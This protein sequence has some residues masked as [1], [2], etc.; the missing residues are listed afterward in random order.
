MSRHTPRSSSCSRPAGPLPHP[1]DPAE[2]AADEG[3]PGGLPPGV[4][5]QHLREGR[6]QRDVPLVAGLDV[7]PEPR[8]IPHRQGPGRRV[9]SAG[10]RSWHSSPGRTPVSR[11]VKN[12]WNCPSPQAAK[13][14]RSWSGSNGSTGRACSSGLL[15]VLQP[16]PPLGQGARL[17]GGR[18]AA[19][20]PVVDLG[21]EP[22]GRGAVGPGPRAVAAAGLV[23]AEVTDEAPEVSS[24]L[25]D[26]VRGGRAWRDTLSEPSRHKREGLRRPQKGKR[27]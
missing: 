11:R 10:G 2:P 24:G 18:G 12:L 27:P 6:D 7:P 1:P 25:A 8:L 16:R 20:E 4:Q 23:V 15:V 26:A 17:E 9:R 14:A 13:D 3:E 21:R 5:A 19:L 22:S